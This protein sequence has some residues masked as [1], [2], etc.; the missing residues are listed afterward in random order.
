VRSG[1]DLPR[2]RAILHPKSPDGPHTPPTTPEEMAELMTWI[3]DEKTETTLARE[4]FG[5]LKT[6][7]EC[8][9]WVAALAKYKRARVL[10]TV[11]SKDKSALL[12][13]EP[14]PSEEGVSP[15]I[16][17]IKD[18]AGTMSLGYG[19]FDKALSDAARYARSPEDLLVLASLEPKDADEDFYAHRKQVLLGASGA[20]SNSA[21]DDGS[22]AK[23]QDL[24]NQH[25][26][27]LRKCKLYLK[28]MRDF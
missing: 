21:W 9:R 3:G 27:W 28:K 7:A 5:K 25:P 17:L 23:F 8:R 15:T 13:L 10:S 12:A 4:I 26:S 24:L 16:S 14:G 11:F 18:F 20:L 19:D 6:I 2:V 1:T 22:R